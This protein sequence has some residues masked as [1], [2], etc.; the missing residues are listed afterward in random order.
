MTR[1]AKL[2]V[3]T[4]RATGKHYVGKTVNTLE[5]RWQCHVGDKRRNKF[6]SAIEQYGP[7]DFEMT[8]L[9]IYPSENE[10]YTAEVDLI[11]ARKSRGYQHSGTTRVKM[12]MAA[13]RRYRR[14]Y[15]W[16]LYTAF[17]ASPRAAGA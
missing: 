7:A 14:E 3:I 1:P 9:Y 5:W 2:Y 17:S 15:L 13:I 6:H 4:C 10:A 16:N 8:L 11:A 12:A